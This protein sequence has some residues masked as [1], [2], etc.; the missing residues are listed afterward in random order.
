MP[1]TEST[2]ASTWTDDAGFAAIVQAC[3]NAILATGCFVQASDTGQFN[4]GSP[5]TRTSWNYLMYKTDDALADV[6]V[7]VEHQAP[8]N[9]S[10]KIRVS[11]GVATNGSGTFTGYSTSSLMPEQTQTAPGTRKLWCAGDAGWVWLLTGDTNTVGYMTGF[12][13]ER[14]HKQ[15]GAAT[16][17][18][19]LLHFPVTTSQYDPYRVLLP[20]GTPSTA[21][22]LTSEQQRSWAF[23]YYGNGAFG[24]WASGADYMTAPFFYPWYPNWMIGSFMRAGYTGTASLGDEFDVDHMGTVHKFKAWK[25]TNGPTRWALDT[26]DSVALLRWE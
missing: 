2:L 17:D 11:M 8:S 24:K 19:A 7:K 5:P 18:C 1:T 22:S 26:S 9:G 14:S 3:H 15:D 10:H 13:F 6:Y 21:V 12:G 23:G 4:F 20:V 16:A 25:H